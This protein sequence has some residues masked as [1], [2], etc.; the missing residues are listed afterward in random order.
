[1]EGVSLAIGTK[2]GGMLSFH[3]SMSLLWYY[4]N[5]IKVTLMFLYLFSFE[6]FKY[7]GLKI[8][9]IINN[10]GGWSNRWDWTGLKK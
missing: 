1:M 8:V 4:D 5:F 10:R 2:P 9:I 6:S 7:L 3:Q